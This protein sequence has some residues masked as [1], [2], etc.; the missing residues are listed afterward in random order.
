MERFFT[1]FWLILIPTQLGRH[2]WLK[3]SSVMGV[4]IDYL[5][6]IFYLTDVVWLVW[7]GIKIKNKKQDFWKEAKKLL[8]FQNFIFVLFVGVNIAFAQAKWV[9]IYRWLRIGQW[10]LTWKVVRK[11]KTEIIVY[12]N[13]IIP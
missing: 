12:L 13:K 9:A 8:N 3:E 1:L 7:M 11:N 10:W 6:I 2:F 4:R 5:S